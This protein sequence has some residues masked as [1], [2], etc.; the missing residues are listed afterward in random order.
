MTKT[1]SELPDA[2]EH[3]D[4]IARRLAGKRLAVFLDYDGTLTPI[5]ARPDLAV[6]SE[7]MRQVVRDLAGRCTVAIVSGRDREDVQK[8]VA[9]DQL[10]YAGDHGFDI[11]GPAGLSIRKDAGAT[12]PT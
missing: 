10:I 3:R 12:S 6:L 4:E 11:S 7:A 2:L 1:I 5:V 8:L 9:L